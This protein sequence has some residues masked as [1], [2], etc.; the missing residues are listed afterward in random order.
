MEIPI[1]RKSVLYQSRQS[2]RINPKSITRYRGEKRSKRNLSVCGEIAFLLTR[3]SFWI[4]GLSFASLM[5]LLYKPNSILISLVQFVRGAEEIGLVTRGNFYNMFSFT[6][7]D[8]YQHC[9]SIGNENKQLNLRQQRSKW[10]CNH[11]LG[12]QHYL[13]F[14][15]F[16]PRLFHFWEIAASPSII[17]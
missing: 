12:I 2:R 16:S 15:N 9:W 5:S 3:N 17:L 11:R 14:T 7:N 10:F 6:L 1:C 4:W 8:V 13:H